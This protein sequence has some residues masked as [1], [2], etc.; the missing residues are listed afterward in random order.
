MGLELYRPLTLLSLG[1]DFQLFGEAPWGYHLTNVL[2]HSVNSLLLY[3]L[4]RDLLGRG[5]RRGCGSLCCTRAIP[6]RLKWWLG[7]RRGATC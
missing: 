6:S 1:L 7:S 3:A 5:S 4:A 2:L